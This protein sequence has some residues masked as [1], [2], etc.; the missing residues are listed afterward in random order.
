MI[1]YTNHTTETKKGKP[2]NAGLPNGA[3]WG[4]MSENGCRPAGAAERRN[5]HAAHPER[6]DR[7]AFH[8]ALCRR[9]GAQ[10]T[11]RQLRR[12]EMA[13][14]AG[15]LHGVPISSRHARGK[16]ARVHR[17]Q[18]LDRRA[19][20]AR[21]YASV[22]GARGEKQRLRQLPHVQRL[23]P[24]GDAPERH[25]ARVQRGAPPREHGGVR[26]HPLAVRAA[27]R[28]GGVGKR[29]RAARVSQGLPCRH[30]RHRRAA[31]RAVVHGGAALDQG[32]PAPPALPQ[33]DQLDAFDI[34][35]YC[36]ECL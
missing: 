5:D 17:H 36:A 33:G 30:D 16:A 2:Q 31:R 7:G 25:G 8:P 32:T 14:C 15:F 28:V 23:R 18:S 22:S 24:A 3:G 12:G 29:H 27:R 4:K 11:V 34:R 13:L 20:S 21:P 6:S 10:R 35:A 19:G 9:H 26:L 1:C